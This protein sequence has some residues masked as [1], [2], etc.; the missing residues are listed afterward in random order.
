MSLAMYCRGRIPQAHRRDTAPQNINDGDDG[1]SEK[2]MAE[3]VGNKEHKKAEPPSVSL[4]AAAPPV[5][6]PS[7]SDTATTCTAGTLAEVVIIARS[8]ELPI[9]VAANLDRTV[10]RRVRYLRKVLRQVEVLEGRAVLNSDQEAKVERKKTLTVELAA[11]EDAHG[12]GMGAVGVTAAHN[13]YSD[14]YSTCVVR[15]GLSREREAHVVASLRSKVTDKLRITGAVSVDASGTV[16]ASHYLPS[17]HYRRPI[18][19]D[20]HRGDVCPRRTNRPRPAHLRRRDRVSAAPSAPS[21]RHALGPLTMRPCPPCDCVKVYSYGRG[22]HGETQQSK[23]RVA[24]CGHASRVRSGKQPSRTRGPSVG[25]WPEPSATRRR[26]LGRTARVL[27]EKNVNCRTTINIGGGDCFYLAAGQ[28]LAELEGGSVAA[29]STAA[30]ALRLRQDITAWMTTSPHNTEGRHSRWLEF[31]KFDSPTDPGIHS[32]LAAQALAGEDAEADT[33]QAT[34]DKRS[35][36]IIIVSD[37]PDLKHTT[38]MMPE[39]GD[40]GLS[41]TIALYHRMGRQN[42][43]G[44]FEWLSGIACLS[45]LRASAVVTTSRECLPDDAYRS[46]SDDHD[47][48]S[49]KEP[50]KKEADDFD[51]P[52]PPWVKCVTLPVWTSNKRNMFT[53]VYHARCSCCPDKPGRDL[54]RSGTA[55]N[56]QASCINALRARALGHSTHSLS[57][58]YGQSKDD[59]SDGDGGGGAGYNDGGDGDSGD[60]DGGDG[61]GG[62]GDEAHEGKAGSAKRRRKVERER[63][64]VGERERMRMRVRGRERD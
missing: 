37:H 38:I 44:H 2:M 41:R 34:C 33:I 17:P 49:D 10:W 12:L 13:P 27:G 9:S 32:Y 58:T 24:R 39:G 54:V 46:G 53:V 18:R 47:Q 56:N 48:G 7:V 8:M 64:R 51:P 28:A 50:G 61:D 3:R 36:N 42:K 30:G 52:F 43:T 57:V 23:R 20:H 63:M 25:T 26:L 35:I 11:L 1:D 59:N 29:A 21:P 14:A 62:S 4:A 45:E 19:T 16:Q 60:G 31:S 6:A 5:A 40:A 15:R 22:E 55:L